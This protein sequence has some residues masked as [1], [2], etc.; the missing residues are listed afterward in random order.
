MTH[1]DLYRH[2]RD[3]LRKSGIDNPE[4]E[5]YAML[6]LLLGIKKETVLLNAKTESSR[7]QI[8]I[9]DDALQKRADG[10]P[11]QYI[12]GI[13]E[14]YGNDFFVGDGVLIPRSDTEILVDMAF[15]SVKS[16]ANPVIIDLCSGSGCVGISLAKLLPKSHIYL[17]EYSD[18][19]IEYIRKNIDLNKV[20]NVF[21]H[22]LDVLDAGKLEVFDNV[23]ADVIVANPPYLTALDMDNLQKEVEFEPKM[24]LFGGNDGLDFYRGISRIWKKYLKPDGM[25]AFEVGLG[26]SD[27]VAEVLRENEFRDVEFERDLIGIERVVFGIKNK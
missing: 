23:T 10:Y 15:D 7:E 11:L 20:D 1:T 3:S 27:Q 8:Q 19:A 14:F 26:Q 17:V 24:A 13:W 18:K 9:I 12:T 22:K 4:F 6:E 16:I 21:L 5:S 2:T 25:I